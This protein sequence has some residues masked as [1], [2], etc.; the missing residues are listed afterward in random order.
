MREVVC[1][2]R[3]M[4][5]RDD[6][7]LASP[8]R[9]TADPQMAYSL[10][11]EAA[12]RDTLEGDAIAQEWFELAARLGGVDMLW[13]IVDHYAEHGFFDRLSEWMWRATEA[14]WL[15]DAYVVERGTLCVCPGVDGGAEF[16]NWLVTVSTQPAEAAAKALVAAAPRMW[17]VYA[18]GCEPAAQDKTEENAEEHGYS[19]NYIGVEAD[20]EGTVR[21]WLDYKGAIWPRMGRTHLRI[22]IEE[23]RAAGAAEARIGSW[24]ITGTRNLYPIF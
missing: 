22:V 17:W 16:Q 10:G 8:M 6:L 21:L 4:P 14:E 20:D 12:Q 23:L 24:T 11:K 18:D 3:T 2:D 19:P 15:D 7:R 1:P 9:T 5:V 13:R